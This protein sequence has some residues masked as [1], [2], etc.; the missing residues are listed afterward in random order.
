MNFERYKSAPLTKDVDKGIE[1]I[2]N[3]SDELYNVETLKRIFGFI[4]LTTLNSTDTVA[5]AKSFCD[6]VNGFSN[7]FSGLP[8]VAAICVYP[9][10][11]PHIKK[12][13]KT[14][15]VNIASVVGGFP[16]SQ[17]YI[18]I[19]TAESEQ[20]VKHGA[21]EADMVISIGSFFE[22][23]Y[24]KVYNEVASIKKAIDDKHLKVILESG[25]LNTIENIWNASLISME[26]GGDFIKTSTGK[27]SPAATIEAAFV[28]CS[29]I[30]E[31]NN[32]TGKKIGFKPAGGI[33]TG[34]EAIKYFAI[35]KSILGDEW[36]NSKYFRF[37]ASSLANNIL[38][39]I[40]YIETGEEKQIKYF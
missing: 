21:N 36:L 10:L 18:E 25:A 11:V 40:H 28:M 4:D 3:N 34:K 14:E 32:K 15:G 5:K 39:E 22:K 27:M 38:S 7:K 29:A 16:A 2:L 24:E 13:L 33:S 23:D 1:L 12:Y 35:V 37:G 8:N 17:T 9:A 26:A 19:K 31:Y 6:N 20:A 30:K